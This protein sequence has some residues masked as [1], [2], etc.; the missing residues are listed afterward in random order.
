MAQPTVKSLKKENEQLKIMIEALTSD[1]KRLE[2]GLE[3]HESAIAKSKENHTSPDAE[4]VKSLEFMS[5]GYDELNN[6]RATAK[7][8]FSALNTRL[9]ELTENV[10]K[11]SNAICDLEQY[12]YSYNVKLIGIPESGRKESAIE[13]STVC[14]NLFKWC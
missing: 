6:F 12:S 5:N 11:I 1:F 13:T 7:Q 14:A 8:T 4:T 10:D 3:S 9:S 2:A